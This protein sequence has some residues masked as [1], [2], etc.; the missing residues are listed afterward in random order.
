MNFENIC[1]TNG[2]RMKFK[3]ELYLFDPNNFVES[4]CLMKFQAKFKL[5]VDSILLQSKDSGPLTFV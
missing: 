1:C 5:F 2:G 4:N 3:A